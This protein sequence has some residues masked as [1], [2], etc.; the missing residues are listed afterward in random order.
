MWEKLVSM[1]TFVERFHTPP[2]QS[3]GNQ[4]TD[5]AKIAEEG[6]KSFYESGLLMPEKNPKRKPSKT[7][8]KY[9]TIIEQKIHPSSP[10]TQRASFFSG[11]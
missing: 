4:Y 2:Q 6:M 7:S 8:S 11:N 3:F 1:S 5:S 9:I 10:G